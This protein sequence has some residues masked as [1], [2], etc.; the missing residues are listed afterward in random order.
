MNSYYSLDTC[1][2]FYIQYFF[3]VILQVRYYWNLVLKMRKLELRKVRLVPANGGAEVHTPVCAP[4]SYILTTV[5]S[6]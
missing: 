4:Q 1:E 3:P 6:E 2:V 5:I